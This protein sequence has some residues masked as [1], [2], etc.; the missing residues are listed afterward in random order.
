MD[1]KSAEP[2]ES[3]AQKSMPGR[4]DFNY[5]MPMDMGRPQNFRPQYQNDYNGRG[6]QRNYQQRESKPYSHNKYD[7]YPQQ[8]VMYPEYQVPYHQ[9]EQ[10]SVAII[11][12]YAPPAQPAQPQ[13]SYKN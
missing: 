9:G 10:P 2:K 4:R 12:P 1:I 3:S 8:Q 5:N 6:Y 11:P 13:Y 7:H